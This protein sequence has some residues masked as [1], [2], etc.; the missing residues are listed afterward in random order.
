MKRKGLPLLLALT[1]AFLMCFTSCG[2]DEVSIDSDLSMADDVQ[3]YINAIDIDYAYDLTEKLAYDE[4]FQ[5]CDLGWRTAG[6]DAEHRCADFL[7]EEMENIGLTDVEKIPTTVDKFQLNGTS[8]TIEETDI[9]LTPAAYQCTGTGEEG[10]TAELVDVG[11]GFDADYEGIDVTGKIVIAQVDQWNESWIDGY[12]RQAYEK[13]AAALISYS[14]SGY[15]ELNEDTANVQDICCA[16]LIPTVAISYNQA[17]DVLDAV[18]NGNTTAN[19]MVD[20]DFAPGEGTTY[21]V[22]GYIKGKSSDQQ[23]IISGHY[24]KYWYGFQDDCAAIGMDFTIA[25]AMIDS[26]YVPEN[27]IAV[28]AHGA[29]E[30]G[31]TDA[32]FD[33]T[34]GAWGMIDNE[35]P[36]W[37]QK[38]I[39]MLNCEMPAF[40]TEDKTLRVSC[41]PEFGTLSKKLISES[42]LVAASGLE[43]DV[44]PVDASNMEDG[45]SYRWH[46]VPYFI[47]GFLGDKFMCQRYHTTEDSKDTWSEDA[48]LG[49]LYWY[50]AYAI[51]I[52]KT[53][54]LEL[55]MTQ[56]CDRLQKNMN[57]TV[58]KEAGVDVKAYKAALKE[59]RTAAE[60]Y[61]KKIEKINTA[62]EEAAAAGEDTDAIRAEGKELNKTTLAIFA[63]IQKDFME[64]SAEDVAY[65]HPTIN[66]NA[67][68]LEAAVTALENEELTNDDETGAL[69]VLYG[70]NGGLEYDYYLFGKESADYTV[71][72]YDQQY[73]ST[74]KTFWGTDCM[75]PVVYTGDTTYSLVKAAAAESDVDYAA[76]AEVYKSALAD[77]LENVKTYADNEVKAMAALT[78]MMK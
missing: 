15:G 10:L 37:A 9:S 62:Y 26:G 50:G 42:G 13:G 36:E 70:L 11:T 56:T 25:K 65:G 1:L 5:D 74:D 8:F 33:W 28:V 64:S 44:E 30:W 14:N 49:N 43:L 31:A 66:S 67:E 77:T 2:S 7:A 54:A 23:I 59:M 46:G 60:K 58:A 40:E 17:Q 53:P 18:K 21:N 16:D 52:D 41:V 35:K 29:E 78:E 57:K 71:K 34:T 12:I 45:V 24:D 61:N 32:Q 6:S 27:D 76:A 69:D 51:Y 63:Q 19:L 47:N 38:T 73:I 72:Q 75:P 4:E 3:N 68:V 22:V 39:A 55:D 48:M 20:A